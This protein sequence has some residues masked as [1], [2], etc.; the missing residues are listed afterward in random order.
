MT[1]VSYGIASSAFHS[2]RSVVEVGN[3]CSNDLLAKTI[4]HDFYVDDY[5]SG[6]NFVAEAHTKV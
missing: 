4:K 6:A 2:T 3:R 1:R 5:I